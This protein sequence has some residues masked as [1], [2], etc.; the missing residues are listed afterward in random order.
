LEQLLS[1]KTIPIK[2]DVSITDAKLKYN[3]KLPKVEVTRNKGGFEMKAEPIKINIDSFEMRKSIG[4]KSV[5]TLTKEFAEDGIKL[6]YEGIARVVE[7]G[8]SLASPKGMSVAEIAASRIGHSI[9][10]VLDFLPSER[11]DISWEGGTLN[12]NYQMD[13]LDFDWDTD[14][15]LHFDFVPGKVQF[16]I[17]NKPAIEI[18]Y[19]GDPI[20]VPPSANPSFAGEQF[21]AEA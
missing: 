19:I 6:C 18:D 1:I 3:T 14:A 7:E 21:S 10:T 11:A 4:L 15:R 8:N 12:I 17:L 16:E 13:S 9:E 20:Y 2:I 5:A